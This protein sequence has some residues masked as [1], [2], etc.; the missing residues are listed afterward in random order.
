MDL[1]AGICGRS[2]PL[3]EQCP[4]AGDC[5]AFAQGLTKDIPERKPK[6]AIPTRQ[7]IMLVLRDADGRLLLERRPPSGVWA[8]LWSLPEAADHDSAR[9]RAASYRRRMHEEFSPLPAFVHA[10]SHYRLE[11]TPLSLRVASSVGIADDADRRW[12]HPHEAAE[13]GLPAPVRKLIAALASSGSS[14]RA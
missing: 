11:V 9:I 10:F 4:L 14:A 2:R 13:L 3:C 8:G 5:V 6:R 12:L 7:T 1:G